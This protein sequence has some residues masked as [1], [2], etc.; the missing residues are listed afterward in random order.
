MAARRNKNTGAENTETLLGVP[1][2]Q[3]REW[4]SGDTAG[5]GRRLGRFDIWD[6]G[7]IT[8]ASARMPGVCAWAC[9]AKRQNRCER[10]RGH[11]YYKSRTGGAHAFAYVHVCTIKTLSELLSACTTHEKAQKIVSKVLI[12]RKYS[13]FFLGDDEKRLVLRFY[14]SRE[15]LV[16]SSARR[17]HS[18]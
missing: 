1:S 2:C 10:G 18:Q 7:N 8:A 12:C 16:G 4:G 17:R 14:L 5:V 11:R 13:L 6:E 15:V 9:N 3:G